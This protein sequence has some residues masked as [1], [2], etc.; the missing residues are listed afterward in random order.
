MRPFLT[1][2]KCKSL[3]VAYPDPDTL[4]G[5][6]TEGTYLERMAVLRLW[7]TE[8]IPFAFRSNPMIYE[9]VREWMAARLQINP[10]SITI[11][12]SGRIGYSVSPL[13]KYGRKFDI[14]SDLDFSAVDHKLFSRLVADYF[15]WEADTDEG[16][17]TPL[18]P[19]QDRF[20]QGSLKQLPEN[21]VRGFIDAYKIPSWK[22][23]A[24]VMDVQQALYLL[25]ERLKATP[26]APKVKRATLRVYRDWRS[27]FGQ[28]SLNLSLTAASF[29]NQSQPHPRYPA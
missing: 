14:E 2:E 3:V 13:P 9:A 28:M 23:Y 27:L 11:I 20:W 15:A 21:I 26:D 8:G 6:I 16:R 7:F 29:G 25:G 18:N 19:R 17:A 22:R 1:S 24:M 10:K 4:S 5:A 12:G